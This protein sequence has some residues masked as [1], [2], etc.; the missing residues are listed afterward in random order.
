MGNWELMAYNHMSTSMLCRSA[1]LRQARRA[2][3]YNLIF[4]FAFTACESV[5]VGAASASYNT[6]VV[7]IAVSITAVVVTS[8]VLFSLQT[9]YD[10]TGMGGVLFALLTTLIIA[11]VVQMF[12]HAP[13]L[14]IAI[15]AGG[16]LLFSV[17]L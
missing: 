14:H 5:L 13:A 16:A 3:P 7:L 8:L 6:E 1:F 11:G 15:C 12:V 4:L 2:H 10:V 17:Y 9:R